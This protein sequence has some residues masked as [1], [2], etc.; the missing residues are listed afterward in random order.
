MEI[1]YFES[2][3]NNYKVIR[4]SDFQGDTCRFFSIDEARL[5]RQE[6]ITA[7]KQAEKS[8]VRRLASQRQAVGRNQQKSLR[9]DFFNMLVRELL[10]AGYENVPDI[11][12]EFKK[13]YSEQLATYNIEEIETLLTS[14]YAG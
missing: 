3:L 6:K 11:V 7:A 13:T 9:G 14:L 12:N 8:Q 10:T 1:R 2:T 4:N 5:F